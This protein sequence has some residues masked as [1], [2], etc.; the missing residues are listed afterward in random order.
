[1]MHHHIQRRY[2]G[3]DLRLK[4]AA[5]AQLTEVNSNVEVNYYL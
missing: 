3:V 5:G 4:M 2:V 1:M